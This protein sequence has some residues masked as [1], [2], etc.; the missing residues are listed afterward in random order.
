MTAVEVGSPSRSVQERVKIVS[1]EIGEETC[2]P[3][4]PESAQ[5][6]P[7]VPLK[8][9]DEA[10]AAPQES[11]EGVPGWMSGEA[12]RESDAGGCTC[13]LPSVGLVQAGSAG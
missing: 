7:F 9:Q 10:L 13:S 5:E 4:V 8:V 1:A 6:S 11:V 2:V 12:V 3:D